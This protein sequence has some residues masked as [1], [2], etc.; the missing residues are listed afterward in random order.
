MLSDKRNGTL[1]LLAYLN[2]S[3]AAPV[4]IA[5]RSVIA[6]TTVTVLVTS[7]AYKKM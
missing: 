1:C 2:V 7:H 4:Q 5:N 6:T 3:L